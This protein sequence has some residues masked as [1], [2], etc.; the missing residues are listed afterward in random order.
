MGKSGGMTSR[1]WLA[2]KVQRQL[3]GNS[4]RWKGSMG[5]RM[6]IPVLKLHTFL[7]DDLIL[8][9][10]KM[11]YRA[12]IFIRLFILLLYFRRVI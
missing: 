11:L 1:K 12:S 3:A 5:S 6:T 10:S 7:Q 8:L 9:G 2:A 4:N